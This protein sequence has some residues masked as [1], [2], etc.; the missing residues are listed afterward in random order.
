MIA[1]LRQRRAF[2]LVELLVVIAIIGVL[3]ALLLPAV[4]AAREAARR[5]SCHNNSKQIA[6]A[7]HNFHDTSGRFPPGY[8]RPIIGADK[9]NPLPSDAPTTSAYGGYV[10]LLPFLEQKNIAD[11]WNLQDYRANLP[12]TQADGATQ[13][14]SPK[15]FT[16]PSQTDLPRPPIER[17]LTTTSDSY[18]GKPLGEWSYANYP[19]NGGQTSTPRASQTL[20]GVFFQNSRTRM[21]EI[22][23]G[24]SNTFLVGERTHRDV[25]CTAVLGPHLNIW[26]WWAYPNS[27]ESSFG[28][29]SPLNYRLPLGMTRAQANPLFNFRINAAGSEHPTGAT[30]AM[31]DGSVRFLTN[32]IDTISYRALSTRAEGETTALP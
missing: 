21:A 18:S 23:D 13:A 17:S 32:T 5:M 22:T 6:L 29:A 15:V 10:V 12:G 7:F 24:T 2:T 16:C 20:D 3:V 4:Q 8:L 11:R 28:T 31:S 27:G 1:G 26:G 25:T 14:Q 30:F 9:G 19:L